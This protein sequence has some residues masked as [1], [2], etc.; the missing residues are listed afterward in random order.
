MF[1]E[2]ERLLLMEPLSNS[3]TPTESQ[4]QQSDQSTEPLRISQVR[5]LQAEA[6]GFKRAKER[7]NLPSTGV[8]LDRVL[9]QRRGD[10]D[11]VLT[12]PQVATAEVPLLAPHSAWLG[13]DQRLIDTRR[14][15]EL[16]D[17]DKLAPSVRHL[18]VLPHAEVEVNPVLS[19]PG[20][21]LDADKFPVGQQAGDLVFAEQ[22]KEDFHNRDPFVGVRVAGFRQDEPDDRVGNPLVD[23]AKHQDIQ[24]GLSELPIGAVQRQLPGTRK[25]KQFDDA[26]SQIGVGEFKEPEEALELLV[27]GILLGL[28]G[29]SAGNFDQ[30]DVFDCD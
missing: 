21:P 28:T 16:P 2:F 11:Q 4:R 22:V 24:I 7:F 1:L 19:Q 27:L 8:L 20:E 9:A 25:P 10:K 5:L 29:K 15:E 18:K 3:M 26:Q 14:A 13:D 17:R 12:A 30:V 23:D 6:S